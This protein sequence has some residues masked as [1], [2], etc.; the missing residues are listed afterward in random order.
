MANNITIADRMNRIPST[1]HSL[2]AVFFVLMGW[3]AETIDLGGT[4]FLMPSIRSYFQ[5]DTTTG[6]FYSSICFLGMFIGAIFAGGIADK[7]G[8]KKVIISAMCVWGVAGFALVFSPNIYYLFTFRFILGLGL[9]A[10]F[11]V[12]LTY[13]SEMVSGEE[14]PKFMTLY[15]LM[16]PIGFSVA[17]LVTVLVL[18]HFD[19]R[20]VYFFEALPA[21]FII[22]IIKAC[23]ESP[24]WLETQGRHEEAEI[25]CARMEKHAMEAHGELPDPV[26]QPD[27]VEKKG[28]YR[29]LFSRRYIGLVILCF[30]I[31][32][33]SMFSDYGLTTWLTTILT[34]KGFDVVSST[35]FVTV[36]I[37]GGIPAWFFVS[38]SAKKLGR[39]KTFL[40]SGICTAVFGILYGGA[41]DFVTLVI[42]GIMYQFGKYANA[43]CLALYTPELYDTNIRAAGNGLA[44]SWGRLG[45]IVGPVILALMLDGLGSSMTMYIATGLV[46]I[47]GLLVFIF[48][49]ETKDKK[50]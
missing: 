42:F 7:I 14:R 27:R 30:F 9:G 38:W 19:W 36:G 16:T 48:G 40:I 44:T 11:P 2:L 13:L 47:P 25:I 50:F 28:R 35:G 31:W 33:I 34:Q 43:M 1:R 45:S 37:L 3:F 10:Q 41:S 18:P 15:Q 6:G 32:F 49:P 23:P 21:L 8:R 26:P 5:M 17:G 4:S 24:L 22:G 29:D 39:K 20:G 12:A 46:V